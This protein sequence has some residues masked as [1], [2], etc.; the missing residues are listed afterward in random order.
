MVL[1]I[2]QTER[3]DYDD[4]VTCAGCGSQYMHHLGLVAY[5]RDKED[6]KTG[7]NYGV[8]RD[9]PGELALTSSDQSKNPS[10][11]RDAI[12]VMLVCE[13]CAQPTELTILQH[14]GCTI[15]HTKLLDRPS[16]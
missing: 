11:R 10:P 9:G 4:A 5:F 8:C 7:R 15:L 3:W 16:K 2:N 14:K 13:G 1:S 6:A 12:V